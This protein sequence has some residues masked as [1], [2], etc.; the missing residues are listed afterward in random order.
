MIFWRR[1][2]QPTPISLPWESHGQ[3]RAVLTKS[4]TQ[5]K[6]LSLHVRS[7][8]WGSWLYCISTPPTCLGAVLSLY[9][10]LWKIFSASL[11]II[12]VDSCFVNI[13]SFGVPVGGSESVT[14]SVM[15]DSL[16]P[17]GLQSARLLCPLDSA[18]KNAGVGCHFLLQGISRTQESN[19]GL[20][21]CRWILYHLSSQGCSL[22]D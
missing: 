4:W 12:L 6:W 2:W 20:L 15:S 19:L 18:G 10:Q 17:H 13:C 5:L 7:Q 9:F 1:K 21:P 3:R 16:W 8:G 22:K 11:Q 14:Q